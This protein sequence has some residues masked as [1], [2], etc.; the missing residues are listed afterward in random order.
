MVSG[1]DT[2]RSVE[3]KLEGEENIPQDQQML[4]FADQQLEDSCALSDYNTNIQ[5][6]STPPLSQPHP[7]LDIA[8]A[9]DDEGITVDLPALS[10]AIKLNAPSNL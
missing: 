10:S 4:T 5:K 8:I 3:P 6:E 1:S 9:S 7:G 2:I